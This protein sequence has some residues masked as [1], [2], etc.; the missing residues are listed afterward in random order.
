MV[1]I[2]F[3]ALAD[4]A[5]TTSRATAATANASFLKYESPLWIYW[6]RCVFW[7]GLAEKP[8]SEQTG[9]PHKLGELLRRVSGGK[10]THRISYCNR[11]KTLTPM[12]DA[13]KALVEH[14][15]RSCSAFVLDRL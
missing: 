2:T 9:R 4:V 6:L 3:C 8:A 7:F 1:P 13:Y 12:R 10:L 15:D 11:V 14:Q 5:P